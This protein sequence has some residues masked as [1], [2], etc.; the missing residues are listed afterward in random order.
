MTNPDSSPLDRI[1]SRAARFM[2]LYLWVHVPLSVFIAV[3]AGTGLWTGPLAIASLALI[4]TLDWWRTRMR[5]GAQITI[6]TSLGLI[7]AFMVGQLN[8]HAWQ[9]DMHMYFFAAFATVGVFCNW[10]P[11]VAYAGTVGI[12]HLLINGLMPQAVFPG[13]GDLERVLL[14]AVVLIVQAA[15]LIWLAQRLTQAFGEAV[16]AI[17]AARMAQAE[18]ERISTDQRLMAVRTAEASSR[19]AAMQERVVREISAG[20]ERLAV[21]DL[22]TQIESPAH[23]PFPAEYDMLRQSFNRV[24]HQLGLVFD[25]ITSVADSVRS[26]SDEIDQAA[27]HL[28]ARAEAQAATLEESAAALQQ[29]TIS[30]RSSAAR[31]AEAQDAGRQNSACAEAG[32][33]VVQDAISAMQSIEHSAVEVTQIVGVIEGIAFQT[34]LLALNAGIE[35]ARAGEAGRGFAVVASEVRS[36]AQRA[37]DSAHDIRALIAESTAHVKAGSAL[38]GRTGESLQE[39]LSVAINVQAAMEDI[40]SA[41]REQ[42]MGLEEINAGVIHLD[43]VTQ[44]NAAIAEQTTAAA[45]SLRQ[46]SADLVN[47]VGQFQSPSR[48][49]SSTAFETGPGNADATRRSGILRSPKSAA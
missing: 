5:G 33:H 35:A 40:S 27:Q 31:A 4:A 38:V 16:D 2:V 25:Q 22:T 37:S 11:L 32:A 39:I 41:T 26:G 18:G 44:Q 1:R 34:N 10:R 43:Q 48:R 14:H 36:L 6:A 30:V 46:R 21:G 49:G 29:M 47:V 17:K 23:N 24:T 20:L 15:A 8:G 13:Q 28:T 42:A 12:H 9:I 7:V 19:H 45:G 3:T